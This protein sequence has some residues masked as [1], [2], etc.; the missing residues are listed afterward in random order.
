MV[1][2]DGYVFIKQ[3][4]FHAFHG[5]MEQER[6]VGGEYAVDV[7]MKANLSKAIKTDVVA[8]TIDYSVVYQ[9][10]KKVMEV[11]SALLEHVA[12][13]IASN[14]FRSFPEAALLDLKITKVNPPMGAHCDGA[15]VVMSFERTPDD[16]LAESC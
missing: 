5:V 9:I 6:K 14:I 13:R 3:M 10:V 11:P 2:I 16:S 15:S 8:D 12:G 1:H 4:H 7:K